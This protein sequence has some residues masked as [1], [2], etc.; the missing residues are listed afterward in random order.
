MEPAPADDAANVRGPSDVALADL[1]STSGAHW[2]HRDEIQHR[3]AGA[4][5]RRPPAVNSFPDEGRSA[6]QQP[7]G[8]DAFAPSD[9]SGGNEAVWE[10]FG[11]LPKVDDSDRPAAGPQELLV[12]ASTTAPSRIS[13]GVTDE[14]IGGPRN[15]PTSPAGPY[16]GPR[17]TSTA[18]A[19]AFGGPR[20]TSTS[21]AGA[22]DGPGNAS[23]PAGAFGAAAEPGGEPW[24]ANAPSPVR[25]LG[26]AHTPPSG[27]PGVGDVL[28]G[29]GRE[30]RPH[31]A[32]RGDH[33]PSA[34]PQEAPSGAVP[35]RSRAVTI[36]TVALSTVVLLAG[37]LAGVVFFAGPDSDLTSVLRL[38]AG[39]ARQDNVATAPLAGRTA[40]SFEMAAATTKVTVRTQDLGDDLYRITAADEAGTVP[41]PVVSDDRVQLQLSSDG[42]RTS[43]AVEVLLS[44]KITWSLR[45]VGAADEQILD[46][47]GGRVS[48]VDLAGGTR[49]VDLT[50][51]QPTGTVPVRVTG[52]IDDLSVTSPSGNP[53]RVQVGGGAKTVTAGERTL[54]D[55]PAGSTL[56]PKDWAAPNRY[57]VDA[58]ARLTLLAVRTS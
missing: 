3:P 2:A 30:I 26:A 55:V 43:G 56:T 50:L 49:R 53:V 27:V 13:F 1:P 14:P 10:T 48:S 57:D 54:R 28:G 19:G 38:G 21:P 52:A 58:A 51:A 33:A 7:D 31:R 42:E 23:A 35:H 11:E 40:A 41:Q 18:P 34:G 22:F 12:P 46:L 16:G 4:P 17:S 47:T 29:E 32:G 25:W 36:A 24:D 20:S 9:N 15:A 6:S 39:T 37:G 8:W 44:T 45:F 5:F